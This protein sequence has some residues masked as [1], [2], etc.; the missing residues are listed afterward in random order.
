MWTVIGGRFAL[1]FDDADVAPIV[2]SGD[3]AEDA[4]LRAFDM[5]S[6]TL[7]CHLFAEIAL[8]K[9]NFH[10]SDRLCNDAALITVHCGEQIRIALLNDNQCVGEVLTFD[11]MT[12]A[13]SWLTAK[14]FREDQITIRVDKVCEGASHSLGYQGIFHCAECQYS[15]LA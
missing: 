9:P 8:T 15:C 3:G 11:R 5:K 6:A 2:F 14:G 13:R 10:A 4:A 12:E 7:N 1:T